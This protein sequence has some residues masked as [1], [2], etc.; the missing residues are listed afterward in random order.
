MQNALRAGDRFRSEVDGLIPSCGILALDR[1]FPAFR[2]SRQVLV[3]SGTRQITATYD[4]TDPAL[5]GDDIS[6]LAEWIRS[7]RDRCREPRIGRAGRLSTGA[8]DA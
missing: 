6:H 7:G 2:S 1:A 8:I 5:L 3:R 4:P